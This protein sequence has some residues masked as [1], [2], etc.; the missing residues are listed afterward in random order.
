ME[1]IRRALHDWM[2]DVLD[3]RGWSAAEW[4]R[5]AD[6]TPTNLTR[7]LRDPARASLPSAETIGN[8]AWAAGTEPRFL[9]RAREREVPPVQR[10]PVL[11]IAQLR[12]LRGLDRV[13]AERFLDDLA[14]GNG[15]T[16][17][18][19]GTARHGAFALRITS[20]HMN[21]G[22]LMPEDH[23][24]LEPPTV[25]A[26]SWGDLVVTVSGYHVCGYRYH[27]PL[28]VPASTDS[29][30][31]PAFVEEET[32]VGVAVQ[33]VRSFRPYSAAAAAAAV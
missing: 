17:L 14:R 7:F 25:L 28:L 22:G 19:D 13:D 4:A 30:C 6:V 15:P 20:L 9:G 31:G 29:S 32:I 16:V 3:Q 26:P 23:V 27:P 10:V 8:L 21:A 33:L 18:L 1:R 12:R 11:T 24:V 5:R 2:R